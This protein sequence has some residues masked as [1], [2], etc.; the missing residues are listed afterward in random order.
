MKISCNCGRNRLPVAGGS[1]KPAAPGRGAWA[2]IWASLLLGCSAIFAPFPPDEPPTYCTVYHHLVKSGGTSIKDQ[3]RRESVVNKL[4]RPGLCTSDGRTSG[5]MCLDALHNSTIIMGYGEEMRNALN[6]TGRRCEFFTMMRHPID[7]LV[8]AFMYCPTD[9]DVQTNRPR[10]WCGNAEDQEEPIE[11]RLIEFAENM[12]TN[13][14]Y[15]TLY[16]S[17][18]CDPDFVLCPSE[19]ARDKSYWPCRLDSPE[20]WDVLKQTQRILSTYTAVGI[21]EEWNLSMALFNAKVK[22]PVAN[23]DS[24]IVR[25]PGLQSKGRQELLEWAFMSPRVHSILSA[26]ILLYHFAVAIFKRQ[27]EETLGVDWS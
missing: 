4:P 16:R 13:M 2:G 7:R 6:A 25:N 5:Q 18:I 14:A 17:I 11:A 27:A 10:K 8:S 26:D 3:L 12:F 21:M 20:S 24:K 15:Q 9:H 1:M 22:S 19:N 23:W